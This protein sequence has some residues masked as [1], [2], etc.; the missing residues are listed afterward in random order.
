M[1]DFIAPIIF[2]V[3][4]VGVIAAMVYGLVSI[5]RRST[6]SVDPGIGTVRRFYFYSVAFVAVM[7]AAS[8]FALFI[9]QILN[10]ISSNDVISSSREGLALGVA[11][12]VVGLPLWGAHWWLIRR[13]VRE[14]P[15]EDRAILRYLYFYGVSAVS[16]IIGLASAI[17]A[18]RWVVG[19][20]DFDGAS[21]GRVFVFAAVWG[22]HLFVIERAGTTSPETT[23]IRRIYVYVTA[24]STLSIFAFNFAQLS[25]LVL[26]IGYDTLVKTEA[27]ISE[28]VFSERGREALCFAIVSGVAWVAHLYYLGDRD[29]NSMLRHIYLWGYSLFGGTVTVIIVMG[30]VVY[31]TLEWLIGVPGQ[32]SA[33][34]HFDFLPGAVA[35]LIVS[36]GVVTVHY[37][38]IVRDRASHGTEHQQSPYK[39]YRYGLAA[40]GLVILVSG[41]STTVALLLSMLSG[42]TAGESLAG[43]RSSSN[44]VVQIVTLVGLGASLW[45]YFWWQAQQEASGGDPTAINALPRRVFIFG[46]LGAGM[47]GFLSGVSALVFL[48]LRAVF[49]ND[50]TDFFGTLTGPLVILV[51]V[52][53]FLPYY[54][55]VYRADRSLL[56]SQ[57]ASIARP[58]LVSLLV[59]PD[60]ASFVPVLEKALGYKVVQLLLAEGKSDMPELGDKAFNELIRN[61]T[62]APTDNV[63]V[64]PDGQGF[65]VLSHR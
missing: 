6:T 27:L 22:Y 34:F 61:I 47:I 30:L 59:N 7:L 43:D 4:F 51:P 63:I 44:V 32:A 52:L 21:W 5:T 45:G 38:V 28:G 55:L 54:W 48:V 2:A 17:G 20:E 14:Y 16:L 60:A 12:A 19:V 11:F 15:V 62:E 26:S 18:L 40:A 37:A 13:Y 29:P 23:A 3:I 8:G 36:M 39:S 58:K 64:I 31:E 24:A 25:Y 46:V 65:R 56:P 42:I 50:F 35:S 10:S 1:D 49:D 57:N 41:T 33:A 9:G 53:I